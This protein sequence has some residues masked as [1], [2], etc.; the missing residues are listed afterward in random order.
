MHKHISEHDRSHLTASSPLIYRKKRSSNSSSNAKRTTMS[1]GSTSSSQVRLGSP[2]NDYK[3][4][5]QTSGSGA[6][7]LASPAEAVMLTSV[8]LNAMA[9]GIIFIF[10]NT[11]MPALSTC[12]PKVGIY[13]MNTINNAIVNPLF[14]F[15]FFGGLISAYPT[16]VMWKNKNEF[17]VAAR[18]YALASTLIYFLGQFLVTIAQNVPRNDALQAVDENTEEGA[19]YWTEQYLKSWVAWNTARGIFAL[20]SAILGAMALVLMRKSHDI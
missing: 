17:S 1:Y 9:A 3:A 20:V 6:W 19:S 10:S 5:D 14:V 7:L 12:E 11:I 8:I 16:G 15:I 4:I 13:V 2:E 18:S